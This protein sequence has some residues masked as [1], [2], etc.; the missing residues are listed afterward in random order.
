MDARLVV[1]HPAFVRLIAERA[2]LGTSL[3]A[4]TVVAYFGF[5]LTVAF[6]PHVLGMP[7][8]DGTVVT[9]GVVVGLALLGLGFVLTAVYVL[10]SNVRLDP[11]AR[12]LIEDL[13]R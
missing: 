3:A 10:V 2:R 9:W 5:I 4:V 6:A 12:S 1:Q 13:D 11:L 7:I 8:H